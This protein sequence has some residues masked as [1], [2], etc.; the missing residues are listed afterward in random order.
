MTL[1]LYLQCSVLSNFANDYCIKLGCGYRILAMI[2]ASSL[3]VVIQRDNLVIGVSI[4]SWFSPVA[5]IEV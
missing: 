3:A 1:Y 5:L 2:T 4:L